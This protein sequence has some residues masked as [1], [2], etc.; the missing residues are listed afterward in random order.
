MYQPG[1]TAKEA[2]ALGLT[3]EEA[4]GPP[5]EVWPDTIGSVLVF[6]DLGSQWVYAGAGGIPTGI[7]YGSIEPVLRVRKVPAE[8]WPQVFDDIRVMEAAALTEMHRQR[9]QRAKQ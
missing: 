8:D 2:A 1:A 3:L 6:D 7:Q 5:I 4:S 9:E